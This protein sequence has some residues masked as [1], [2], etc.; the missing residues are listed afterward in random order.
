VVPYVTSACLA[1]PALA[2]PKIGRCAAEKR[3][4]FFFDRLGR[5]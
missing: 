3:P 2:D 5:G 1:G 4:N